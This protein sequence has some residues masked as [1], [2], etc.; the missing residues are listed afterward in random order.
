MITFEVQTPECPFIQ[1]SKGCAQQKLTCKVLFYLFTERI[2]QSGIEYRFFPSEIRMPR[3]SKDH[4]G[5]TTVDFGPSANYWISR[6]NCSRQNSAVLA[7][8]SPQASSPLQLNYFRYYPAKWEAAE[9]FPA[10]P[11]IPLSCRWSLHWILTFSL[12]KASPPQPHLNLDKQDRSTPRFWLIFWSL[13]D[14]TTWVKR[15]VTEIVGKDTGKGKKQNK[16]SS[17]PTFRHFSQQ[18]HRFP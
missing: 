7:S 10:A 11:S 4:I 12:H 9:L 18:Q 3:P 13:S 17:K 8:S 14:K 2:V 6:E 16:K 5:D 15:K 1:D